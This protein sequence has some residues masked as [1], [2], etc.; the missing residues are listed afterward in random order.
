MK[1]TFFATQAEFRK[2]LEKYHKKDTELIVGYYKVGSRK[3][4]MTW[5][6]SVDQALCFGWIDGV[7]K[8][9]DE[10]SYCIRFTPRRSTSIWSSININKVKELTKAGLM[11]LEGQKAFSLRKESKS[12]I[13][14][15]EKEP[16]L[17]EAK[18]E[19]QF[20]RNKLAW[21]F[22]MKQAPSYKKV[23]THWIM[24]AKQEKTRQL[25]LGKTIKTSELQKRIT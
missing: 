5:P 9:I 8:S 2:W 21:N 16:V 25:R 10:E 18:Y 11:T 7:R 20:R 24:S 12:N 23:I 15:Y 13:Y 6:Q 3:T 19:K 14:S 4:S 22:F 1:A 17:L